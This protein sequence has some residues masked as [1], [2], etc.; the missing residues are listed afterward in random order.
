[1]SQN[2]YLLNVIEIF[3]DTGKTLKYYIYVCSLLIP[4]KEFAFF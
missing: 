2:Q 3:N 1:V 4:S